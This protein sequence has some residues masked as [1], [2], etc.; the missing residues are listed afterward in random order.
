MPAIKLNHQFR[1]D[2]MTDWVGLKGFLQSWIGDLC[3][4]IGDTVP[5]LSPCVL[6]ICFPI[7]I[8]GVWHHLLLRQRGVKGCQTILHLKQSNQ[9]I[10]KH[11]SEN[12]LVCKSQHTFLSLSFVSTDSHFSLRLLMSCST[13][14]ST[15]P[16]HLASICRPFCIKHLYVSSLASKAEQSS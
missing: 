6:L 4:T 5:G 1:A 14:V 9:N 13:F 10:P 2:K 12:L 15:D 11:V 16:G 3:P 7:W 8:L